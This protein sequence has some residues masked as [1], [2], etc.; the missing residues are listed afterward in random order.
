MWLLSP[1]RLHCFGTGVFQFV[2]SNDIREPTL[3]AHIAYFELKETSKSSLHLQFEFCRKPLNTAVEMVVLLLVAK[4]SVC[5]CVC[6]QFISASS[7]IANTAQQPRPKWSTA[8]L[9]DK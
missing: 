4:V 2:Y 8:S 9:S 7:L 5:V 3:N 6:V 1:Y